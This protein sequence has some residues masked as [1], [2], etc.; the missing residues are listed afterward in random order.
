MCG[1]ISVAVAFGARCCVRFPACCFLPFYHPGGGGAASMVCMPTIYW[2]HD[3]LVDDGGSGS[4]RIVAVDEPDTT[5][6]YHG[7]ILIG[8]L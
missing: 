7:S 6:V 1:R 5:M 2:I 3:V 4:L 8:V